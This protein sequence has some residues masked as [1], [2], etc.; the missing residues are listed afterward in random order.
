MLIFTKCHGK[1]INCINAARI[2]NLINSI[3]YLTV[4]TTQK[5]II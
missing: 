4:E 1:N 2:T 3:I 5:I